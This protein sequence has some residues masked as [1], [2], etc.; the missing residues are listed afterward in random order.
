M[1]LVA[2]LAYGAGVW[3]GALRQRSLAVLRPDLTNWPPRR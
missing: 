2:D 3:R 1:R